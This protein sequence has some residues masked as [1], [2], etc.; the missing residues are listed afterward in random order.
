MRT[1]WAYTLARLAILAVTFG[2]LYVAGARGV[3]LV[4][5]AFGVSLLISYWA[6]AGMRERLALGVQERAERITAKLDEAARAED[7]AVVPGDEAGV[8]GDEDV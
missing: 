7:E 6:L 5:L 2:V 4:V 8:P 1:F 3:L